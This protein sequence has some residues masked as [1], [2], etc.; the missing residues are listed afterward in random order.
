MKT[1]KISIFKISKIYI[2]EK[3]DISDGRSVGRRTGNRR[4]KYRPFED[5]ERDLGGSGGAEMHQQQQKM[6][7]RHDLEPPTV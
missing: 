5:F 7:C 1:I 6:N 4:F 2:F 3:S